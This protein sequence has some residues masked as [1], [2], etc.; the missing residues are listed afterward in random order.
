MPQNLQPLIRK[1]DVFEQ[2]NKRK[3]RV[4]WSLTA[5]SVFHWIWQFAQQY[6]LQLLYYIPQAAK[7]YFQLWLISWLLSKLKNKK[8]ENKKSTGM[9]SPAR[10]LKLFNVLLEDWND[11]I[12][13]ISFDLSFE[14]SSLAMIGTKKGLFFFCCCCSS[15]LEMGVQSQDVTS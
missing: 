2:L 1:W 15:K 13:D 11:C 8:I 12:V 10:S 6:H 3:S 4:K 14:A 9:L 7:H 5:E